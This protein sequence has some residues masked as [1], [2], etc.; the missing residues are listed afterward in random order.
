[1]L[2]KSA[3]KGPG[4]VPCPYL[5]KKNSFCEKQVRGACQHDVIRWIPQYLAPQGPCQGQ[6][7]TG[8][9]AYSRIYILSLMLDEVDQ[10]TRVGSL[11]DRSEQK[12]L[13]PPLAI[14]P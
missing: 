11:P 5:L 3:E 2:R 13:G 8:K 1:M 6:V 9:T 4:G 7:D 10:C 14:A 12:V